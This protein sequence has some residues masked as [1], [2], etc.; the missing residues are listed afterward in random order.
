M[1]LETKLKLRNAFLMAADALTEDIEKQ[2]PPEVK[3]EKPT[4]S[5]F[6]GLPW[7]LKKG[8]RS[9]YEQTENN[10]SPEFKILS[11]YVKAHG[12]FCNIFGFKVWLHNNNENLVDRKR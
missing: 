10:T 3:N 2:A 12:G 4:E 6:N 5:Q 9:D 11:N 7:T 8:T 1:R